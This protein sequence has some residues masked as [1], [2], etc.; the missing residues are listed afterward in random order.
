MKMA[1]VRVGKAGDYETTDVPVCTVG[2]LRWWYGL[3]GEIVHIVGEW[4]E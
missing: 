3:F 1:S 2:F 4:E